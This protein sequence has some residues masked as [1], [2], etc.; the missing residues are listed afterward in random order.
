MHQGLECLA[1]LQGLA[2]VG[3]EGGDG[4][5]GAGQSQEQGSDLLLA[6]VGPMLVGGG[7]VLQEEVIVGADAVLGTELKDDLMGVD[8]GG[9][10]SL[11]L[12]YLR[13][14][15]LNVEVLHL[16][17]VGE[18][19]LEGQDAVLD[20][21]QLVGGVDLVP[22]GAELDVDGDGLLAV[23]GTLGV[24]FLHHGNGVLT[25]DVDE[26]LGGGVHGHAGTGGVLGHGGVGLPH[27]AV[28]H[29]GEENV[30]GQH[31]GD[32]RH[33]DGEAYG[34]AG[35]LARHIRLIGHANF[36]LMSTIAPQTATMSIGPAT[37]AMVMFLACAVVRMWMVVSEKG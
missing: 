18:L 11:V 36:L 17:G 35:T 34:A 3:D 13:G 19:L 16:H 26:L 25:D 6:V 7:V 23:C 33:G 28:G 4:R 32:D 21:T 27:K 10:G 29:E 1:I 20:H 12:L 15:L 5:L 24:H 2:V 37:R 30:D 31:G 9:G 22:L 14:V 8:V